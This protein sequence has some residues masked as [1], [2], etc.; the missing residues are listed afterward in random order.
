MKPEDDS[1]SVWS[2]RIVS[3]KYPMYS[4]L[5]CKDIKIIKSAF[6]LNYEAYKNMKFELSV[7]SF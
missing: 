4:T 6:V 2:N 3:L 5:S 1:L 7:K